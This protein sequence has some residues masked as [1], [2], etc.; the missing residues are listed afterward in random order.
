MCTGVISLEA[1]SFDSLTMDVMSTLLAQ[2]LFGVMSKYAAK[3]TLYS[4]AV[5]R[6]F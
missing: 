2:T 5:E 1:M 4:C 6:V 3:C